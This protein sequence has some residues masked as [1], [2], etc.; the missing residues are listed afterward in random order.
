MDLYHFTDPTFLHDPIL[1]GGHIEGIS[2]Y[3][4]I[5]NQ[6]FSSL[7]EISIR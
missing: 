4:Q 2:K 6:D 3:F 1:N 7:E 5:L